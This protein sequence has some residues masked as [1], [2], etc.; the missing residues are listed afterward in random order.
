[1]QINYIISINELNQIK[2][3]STC[4]CNGSSFFASTC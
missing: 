2:L 3:T 4:N 1:M